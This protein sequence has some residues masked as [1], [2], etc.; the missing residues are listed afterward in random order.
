MTYRKCKCE[1]NIPLLNILYWPS[2]YGLSSWS[3]LLRTFS[4]VTFSLRHSYSQ[5]HGWWC[6][7]PQPSPHVIKCSLCLEAISLFAY[8]AIS[9]LSSRPNRKSW[10]KTFP[11]LVCHQVELSSTYTSD[12]YK[13][14]IVNLCIYHSVSGF[15]AYKLRSLNGNTGADDTYLL[16]YFQCLAQCLTFRKWM[17]LVSNYNCAV[18]SNSH[19]S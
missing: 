10:I 17:K 1:F 13:L 19:I 8:L 7:C 11:R 5:N 14:C 15:P 18:L 16:L 9:N 2:Q 4:D 12:A 6:H 3:C